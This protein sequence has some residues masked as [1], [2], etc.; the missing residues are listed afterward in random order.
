M[1]YEQILER[2]WRITWQHKAL[3]LFAFLAGFSAQFRFNVD[4]QMLP[5]EVQRWIAEFVNGPYFR[6][7]VVGF[8]VFAL[9]VGVVAA[10]VNALGR[11]ALID[12]VNRVE[13]GSAATIRSGWKAAK[14]YVWR[15]FWVAFLLGL[16]TALAMAVALAPLMAPLMGMMV[17]EQVALTSL[18]L[19]SRLLECFLPGC[20]VAALLG[21]FLQCIQALAER[22]C[23]LEDLS[24][25]G[26]IVRGWECLRR[27]VGRVL[28]FW[29]VLIGV[30]IAIGVVIGAPIC[31]LLFVTALP[32]GVVMRDSPAI[33]MGGLCGLWLLLWVL[34]AAVS[35]V[36]TTYFSSCW[37]LFYRRLT[38]LNNAGV[39]LV[40]E[41]TRHLEKAYALREQSRLLEALEKCETAVR[42]DSGLAE[43]HNL[44]GLI[45]DEL[46]RTDEAIASY[47]E[48]LRLDPNFEDAQENLREIE[49]E[50]G[51]GDHA[52]A[53]D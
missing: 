37:T 47:R 11:S 52:S 16:P 43:A 15:V 39:G 23:V 22:A 1:D 13:E 5:P 7:A 51:T 12:Q 38:E 49:I 14:R 40:G 32:L 9:L 2:A 34:G 18:D 45:L 26:S 36:T 53:P 41:A 25:W 6:P 44:R 17:G 21:L 4:S 46:G 3:W 8:S 28:A 29:L 50:R 35:C 20:C 33:G 19:E 48:A 10:F 42:I 31:L 24:I 30:G 27:N